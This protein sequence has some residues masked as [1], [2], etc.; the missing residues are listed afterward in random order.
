MKSST[1]TMSFRYT[2][3]TVDCVSGF[4][5]RSIENLKS[6]ATTR[7]DP[8]WNSTF[9][10]RWKVYTLPSPLV[11]QLSA[12]SGITLRSLSNETSPENSSTMYAA[13]SASDAQAGSSDIGS[14]PKRRSSPATRCGSCAVAAGLVWE[15]FW[16]ELE[17]SPPP[18]ASSAIESPPRTTIS[19]T[20]MPVSVRTSLRVS[21][22]AN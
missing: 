15:P 20:P 7:R 9:L 11:S 3:P 12:T 19:T 8:S 6:S 4:T 5:A 13:E 14:P 17:P 21:M 22:R 16:A 18:V 10:R 1:P 2:S